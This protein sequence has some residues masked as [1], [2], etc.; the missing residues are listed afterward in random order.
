MSSVQ[1]V[2]AYCGRVYGIVDLVET[3]TGLITVYVDCEPCPKSDADDADDADDVDD[4][5][6][7]G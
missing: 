3:R 2:C 5:T 4:G 1:V 6:S 7:D